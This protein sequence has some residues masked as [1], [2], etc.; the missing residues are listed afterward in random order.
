MSFSP[1]EELEAELQGRQAHPVVTYAL[2]L[3]LLTRAGDSAQKPSR[4]QGIMKE[5]GG[6]NNDWSHIERKRQSNRILVS[7][8]VVC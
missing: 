6:A 4:G 8:M 1:S 7:S 2:S 5:W 3:G